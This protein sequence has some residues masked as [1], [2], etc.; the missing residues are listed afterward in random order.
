MQEGA[1]TCTTK[2]NVYVHPDIDFYHIRKPAFDLFQPPFCNQ[3]GGHVEQTQQKR[4]GHLQVAQMQTLLIEHV[5][6]YFKLKHILPDVWNSNSTL[7]NFIQLAF[8]QK[9]RVSGFLRLQFYSDL[10]NRKYIP[11]YKFLQHSG[12]FGAERLYK[13]IQFSNKSVYN[14]K[15]ERKSYKC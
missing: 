3:E 14:S 15:H 8:I 12:R 7:K 6:R 11:K 13:I 5:P 2:G 1:H 4:G 9:L 10:L